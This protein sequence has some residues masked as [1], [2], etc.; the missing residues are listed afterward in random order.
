MATTP[1]TSCRKM[2]AFAWAKYYESINSR[3]RYDHKNHRLIKENFNEF[4]PHIKTI[5]EDMAKEL[6]KTWE[7]PV[8]IEIIEP[9]K[10]HITNCGHFFCKDC[11]KTYKELNASNC[12]CPVCR[13]KL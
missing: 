8:C 13:R 7:C 10:L 3:L 1:H 11:F 9:D 6:K 2:T 4:P 5:F 12:M